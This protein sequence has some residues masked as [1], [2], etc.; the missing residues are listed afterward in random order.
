M[1]M[2]QRGA[3]SRNVAVPLADQV[4]IVF[5]VNRAP[6]IVGMCVYE[7]T[8]DA[9][10]EMSIG[11]T[12]RLYGRIGV[13]PVLAYEGPSAWTVPTERIASIDRGQYRRAV[14]VPVGVVA[15]RVHVN[16]YG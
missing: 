16:T 6:I 13:L 5:S 7:Q 9:V 10:L 1:E 12:G 14:P 4:A 11:T 8:E 3:A 2:E 15:D